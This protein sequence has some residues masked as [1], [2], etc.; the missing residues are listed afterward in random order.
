M[1]SDLRS[2]KFLREIVGT[3]D[4]G[5]IAYEGL[6]WSWERIVRAR[7]GLVYSIATI[8]GGH[9]DSSNSAEIIWP[10]GRV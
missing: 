9:T 3:W 10:I 4:A 8:V 6:F 1:I 2:S 5:D 7:A